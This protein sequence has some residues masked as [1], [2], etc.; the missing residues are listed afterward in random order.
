MN[1]T[2]H[3]DVQERLVK[4]TKGKMTK[5]ND[6][7]LTAL[8]MFPHVLVFWKAPPALICPSPTFPVLSLSIYISLSCPFP[9]F[10]IFWHRICSN[11]RQKRA[12]KWDRWRDESRSR[13]QMEGEREDGRRSKE[14]SLLFLAAGAILLHLIIQLIFA[15]HNNK[16]LSWH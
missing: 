9:F 13:R 3:R 11:F 16:F 2:S 10:G 6:I 5:I 14:Q 12:R 8:L 4:G 1:Y 7:F 15:L